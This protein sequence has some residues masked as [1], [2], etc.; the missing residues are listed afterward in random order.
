M[1]PHVGPRRCGDLA[2]LIVEPD[3]IHTADGDPAIAV[4]PSGVAGSYSS[5]HS[6]LSG[7]ASSSVSSLQVSNLEEGEAL[8]VRTDRGNIALVRLDKIQE[9]NVGQLASVTIEFKVWAS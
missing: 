9:D 3:T 4:L 1:F 6:R 8:C 2:D 7:E 5:C